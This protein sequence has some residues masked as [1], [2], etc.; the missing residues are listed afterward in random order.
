M[1]PEFIAALVSTRWFA[2]LTVV[3]LT[4]PFWSSAI[5]KTLHWRPA[6]AEMRGAR[7]SPAPLFAASTI[8]VQAV[9]SLLLITGFAPWL[10]AGML[11]GFTVVATVIAHPF[12]KQTKRSLRIQQRTVAF[13]H[14]GL[15]G[16]LM[17]AVALLEFV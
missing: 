15:I 17:L 7:L 10:G 12:W 9:G 13:E 14:A 8:A 1:T 3:L 16:G 2:L 6:V 11:A 4:L 5:L